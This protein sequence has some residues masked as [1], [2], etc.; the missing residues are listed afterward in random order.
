MDIAIEPIELLYR[1]HGPA[2]LGYLRRLVG[3]THAAQDLLQQTFLQGVRFPE[4]LSRA[5]SPR[6]WLFGVARNM[7]RSSIRRRRK[8]VSLPDQLPADCETED[9]RIEPMRQAIAALP[10]PLQEALELRLGRDL[11]YQEIAE[12]LEIPIGTVRSRLHRAVDRLREA[13]VDRQ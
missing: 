6:A 11:S 9:P 12:V 4:R 7:A 2:I 13:L 10:K 3:D 1:A 5:V 8:V